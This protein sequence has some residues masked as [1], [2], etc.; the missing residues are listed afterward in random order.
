MRGCRPLVRHLWRL[1]SYVADL[2][3]WRLQ[4][5]GAVDPARSR[6][7]LRDAYAG[8]CPDARGGQPPD[9]LC[10]PMIR[11]LSTR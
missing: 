5:L 8:T 6:C 10:D 11:V 1:S 4:A 3:K 7:A 9:V 2:A